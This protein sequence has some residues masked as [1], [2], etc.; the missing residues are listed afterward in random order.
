MMKST[1]PK[2]IRLEVECNCELPIVLGDRTQLHQLLLNLCVNARDAMPNGGTLT[3][4]AKRVEMD[5]VYA[6]SIPD[7]KPGSYVTLS[8]RDDGTGISPEI[9]EQIFDPFFSTKGPEKGTGLG[10]STV[11]GIAKSHGGFVQVTSQLGQ[12][13]T[14]TVYLPAAPAGSDSERVTKAAAEFRGQG[15]TILFVDDETAVREIARRVLQ[16]LNF[17]V[18]TATD[19]VDGLMQLAEHRTELRV[20]VTDL[21][22]PHMDGRAFVRALRRMLPDIPV[23]VASGRMEDAVAGEF[24]TLGVTQLL[25]K[26][27]TENQLSEVLKNLLG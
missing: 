1:F 20:I 21:H 9:M 8:V 16:R 13:S 23:V 24:K 5:A 7:A 22:M 12:G 10:L 18:V 27:F 14:F 2:R 11:M 17:K 25:R 26:P 4:E 6:S 15:E 3:L 19:G